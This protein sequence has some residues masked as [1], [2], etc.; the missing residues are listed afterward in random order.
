[1]LLAILN[2]LSIISV[3][4]GN[5]IPVTVSGLE[6]RSGNIMI[7]VYQN[8]KTFLS[9]DAYWSTTVTILESDQQVVFIEVPPANDFAISVFID[10][11][12]DGKLN[13]NFMGIPNEPYGFSNDPSSHF[14]P[15]SFEQCKVNRNL[16]TPGQ[17]IVIKVD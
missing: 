8:S 12:K 16:L 9:D 4:A 2:F 15:P 3:A 7:A 10:T 17:T 5:E 14:G 13:K 11:N 1:M 6:S